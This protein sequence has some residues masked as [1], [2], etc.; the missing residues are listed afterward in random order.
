MKAIKKKSSD[1][2]SNYFEKELKISKLV[3]EKIKQKNV[4]EVIDV[5]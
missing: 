5:I 4:V 1:E 3:K 2:K